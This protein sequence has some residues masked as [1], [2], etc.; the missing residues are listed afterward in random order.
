MRGRRTETNRRKRHLRRN[1]TV[2]ETR[3]WLALLDRRLGGFKFVRQV[4]I[5][6]YIA[7]LVCREQMLVIEVDGGQH[8]ESTGDHIRDAFMKNEGYRVLR[9]WNS[10]VL[11][12][13]DGVLNTI[14]KNLGKESP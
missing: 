8:S 4:P 2:A 3:L 9:F 12:N 6:S 11:S 5:G 10:D 7:D 14:L 1:S 13:Y